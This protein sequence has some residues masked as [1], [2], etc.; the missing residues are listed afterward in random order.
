MWTMPDGTA[1][2]HAIQEGTTAADL[3]SRAGY[4][5]RTYF[6]GRQ[7]GCRCHAG[8]AGVRDG[9][10]LMVVRTAWIRGNNQNR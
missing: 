10:W 2:Q 3:R 9:D 6:R 1:T 8:D 7:V 5:G 4:T